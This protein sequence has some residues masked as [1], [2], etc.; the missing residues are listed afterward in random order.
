METKHFQNEER[1][2][3][4]MKNFKKKM[5]KWKI[6]WFGKTEIK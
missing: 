4:T 5:G 6:L 2:K 3:N 1:E